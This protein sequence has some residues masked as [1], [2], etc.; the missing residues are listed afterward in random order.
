MDAERAATVFKSTHVS[1][2]VISDHDLLRRYREDYIEDARED[3][4]DH[5]KDKV[6]KKSG[7]VTLT[8]EDKSPDVV[9][10]MLTSFGKY[11][12]ESFIRISTSSAGAER[13]FLEQRVAQA[14][15]DLET[16][17]G[18]WRKFAEQNKVVDIEAQARAVVE[19]MARLNGEL[20]AKQMELSFLQRFAAGGESN[21]AQVA[22]QIAILQSRLASLE[23][24]QSTVANKEPWPAKPGNPA[25]SDRGIFPL[26][27]SM[28]RLQVELTQQYRELKTQEAVFLFLTQMY[29]MARVNEARSTPAFQMLDPPFLPVK[30]ARPKRLLL[31]LAGMLL[32]MIV[33][34]SWAIGGTWWRT[35]RRRSGRRITDDVVGMSGNVRT[36]G[37]GEQ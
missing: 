35:T 13:R 10:A 2:S 32:G 4:W 17:A 33:G 15:G 21:T 30:H 19:M 8:C 29:E 31:S 20:I 12:N 28:P 9:R 18:G 14:R 5:C 36:G 22:S 23:T 7:V 27:A 37:A 24:G 1:D 11:A 16:A 25:T 3:L 26:A 6:E 34:I